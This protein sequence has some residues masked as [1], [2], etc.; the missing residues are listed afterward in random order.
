MDSWL[1]LGLILIISFIS[2]N[3]DLIIASLIVMIIKIFPFTNKLFNMIENNGLNLGVIVI[4]IT[5][6]IPIAVGKIGFKDLINVFKTPAG[7]IAI[8][9]GVLVS[10]LSKWGINQLSIT[11]QI[12]V[13]LLF[14][15]I[16][17]VVFLRGV[18]SGPIIASGI[19]YLLITLL[20]LKF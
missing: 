5:I 11:P 15:T 7:W 1:F 14:G 3:N 19:V 10:I 6:L 12:T 18:A 13:A 2:K 4:S 8:I 9:C 17:G 16:M 20:H